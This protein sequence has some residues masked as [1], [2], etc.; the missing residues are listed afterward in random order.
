MEKLVS[1]NL[2]GVAVLSVPPVV[3]RFAAGSGV[4]WRAAADGFLNLE[5]ENVRSAAARKVLVRGAGTS[6]ILE[7]GD[8]VSSGGTSVDEGLVDDE[9]S[10]VDV[11]LS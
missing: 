9:L 6:W 3:G 5:R 1:G 10:L 11:E 4:C 8:W 2:G 7:C